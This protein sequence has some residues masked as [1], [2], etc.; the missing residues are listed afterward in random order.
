MIIWNHLCM[1]N[2][3]GKIYVHYV[4][5]G[6]VQIKGLAVSIL[7]M[8]MSHSLLCYIRLDF[9]KSC[10]CMFWVAQGTLWTLYYEL[11]HSYG[12]N[13]RGQLFCFHNVAIVW[14]CLEVT[15][16]TAGKCSL[17]WPAH[18]LSNSV[19]RRYHCLMTVIKKT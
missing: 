9:V 5:D 12:R 10:F 6:D 2:I 4:I 11:C 3:S 7:G 15:S 17:H 16:C 13:E 14:V 1:L 18:T 8:I 19:L